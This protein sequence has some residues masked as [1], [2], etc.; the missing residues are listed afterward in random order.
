MAWSTLPLS[1][2]ISNIR[3][4]ELLQSPALNTKQWQF[5]TWRLWYAPPC[6]GCC[7]GVG[8]GGGTGSWHGLPEPVLPAPIWI[9][10]AEEIKQEQGGSPTVSSSLPP[11]G[12]PGQSRLN[13]STCWDSE[14]YSPS[15]GT[16]SSLTCLLGSVTR[17]I[18]LEC[19]YDHG[20]F[21]VLTN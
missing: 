17:V 8:G 7:W 18:F 6:L 19:S 2:T 11:W 14:T 4:L 5:T 9:N 20:K 12:H 16:K 15:D 3:P 1:C 13:L 10:L 21:H